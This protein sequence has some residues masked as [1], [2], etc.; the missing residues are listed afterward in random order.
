MSGLNLLLATFEWL[1]IIF[2]DVWIEFVV[3]LLFCG[4]YLAAF[5]YLAYLSMADVDY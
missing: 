4:N 1:L 3:E 2:C 5:A